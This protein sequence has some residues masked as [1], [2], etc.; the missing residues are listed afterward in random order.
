MTSGEEVAPVKWN[1]ETSDGVS[2]YEVTLSL[3]P[4]LK[5]RVN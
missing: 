2:L 4:S 1:N 3:L 5:D